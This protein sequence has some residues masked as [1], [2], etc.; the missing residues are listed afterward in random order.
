MAS[1]AQLD[2]ARYVPALL[3]FLSNKL[4]SGASQ[5]YRKHFEIGV[6]EWRMLSMLAVE[7]GITANRICQVIGLDKSAVSRSLHALEVAGRVCT[8]VDPA[9]GRRYTVS[10]TE[11]GKELYNRVLKVALERE[12]RLLSGLSESE[13]DTLINLLG[14]LNA[15]VANVNEYDP[16]KP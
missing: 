13:V 4:S 10:L 1:E 3:N 12:R 8:E 6:V 11:S 14:R 9:D 7:S 5:C 15:Q 2:L 16:E